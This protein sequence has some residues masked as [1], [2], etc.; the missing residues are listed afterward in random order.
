[1]RNLLFILTAHVAVAV[2][3]GLAAYAV[4]RNPSC[5]PVLPC[6]TQS[7]IAVV[8]SGE[9]I[10]EMRLSLTMRGN[11]SRMPRH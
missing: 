2:F 6:V 11:P 10:S 1:M 8:L 7:G 9:M 3:L 5:V 4:A